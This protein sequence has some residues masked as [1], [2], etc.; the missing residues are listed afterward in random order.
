MRAAA[1]LLILALAVG[2]NSCR[3]T[4]TEPVTPAVVSV[5]EPEPMASV[6]EPARSPDPATA[7]SA[8][9]D[10]ATVRGAI[11]VS[12]DFEGKVRP[13]LE[14]RCQPCHFSGGIMYQRLPFD[15]PETIAVLGTKLFS[16]IKDEGEQHL[17]REYL[18]Q[19]SR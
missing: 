9:A 8:S 16:R 1:Q 11:Q 13:I 14:S 18:G 2:A 6:P 5:R 17:I 3:H 4:R 7:V 15:R 19:Q 10:T 12:A